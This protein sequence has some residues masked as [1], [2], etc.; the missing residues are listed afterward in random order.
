MT[1]RVFRSFG[2]LALENGGEGLLV[3]GFRKRGQGLFG[4]STWENET[5]LACSTWNSEMNLQLRDFVYGSESLEWKNDWVQF[6][7]ILKVEKRPRFSFRLW[8]FLLEMSFVILV[9]VN[10]FRILG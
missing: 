2:I 10:G 4:Y 9:W 5:I 1:E 7:G 3:F 6:L 8:I